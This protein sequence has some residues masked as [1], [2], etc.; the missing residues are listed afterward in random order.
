[1]KNNNAEKSRFWEALRGRLKTFFTKNLAIKILSLVF[2]MLLWGYV[3]MTQN[4]QR[5]KTI[6]NV[7]VSI[8]GEADLTTRKLTIRGDRSALL[9][10]IS[11]RV[12]TQLT[13]YADLSADDITASIN[14]SE[15]SSKGTHTLKINVRSSTGQVVSYSPSQIEVEI[16]TLI[17]HTVP[18]EVRKEG[19]LPDGYWA[20]DVQLGSSVITLEGA[21]TDLMQ[22]AKAVGTIDLTDRTENVNQSMVLT[23]CDEDGNEID[24]SILFGGLPTIVA[25]LEILPSKLVPI[26]VDAAII[27]RDALPE[28]FEIVSDGTSLENNLVR[29]VGDAESIEKVTSLSLETLDVTGLTESVQQELAILVP[30]GVRIV[31]DSTVNVQV[32]IREKT[33]TLSFEELP[34]EIVGLARGQEASLNEEL[35]ELTFTGRVSQLAGITRGDITVY[36]DVTGLTAGT[37]AVKLAVQMNG[38]D[39][40]SDLQCTFTS[41]DT[42][43]VTIK[44]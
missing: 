4:P 36:A 15:I 9:D 8:E 12:K 13:S 17:T 26:D 35:A 6:S 2:A 1:M 33:G 21:A 10:D 3:L 39:L 34:I 22:I 32:T 29:I 37:H 20:G 24:S 43:Q 23:L 27:G 31:G 28:N 16:D 44:E 42:V 40:P 18:V 30:E 7:K 19:E 5:E 25:K 11:V 14:L 38:E 41:A